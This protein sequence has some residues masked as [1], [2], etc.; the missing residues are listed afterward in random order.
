MTIGLVLPAVPGYS[1]TFFKNKILGLQ[2]YGH[3]VV[4]FVG[5]SKA[6]PE[7]Y[8]NC[9]V[10][11]APKLRGNKVLVVVRSIVELLKATLFQPKKSLRL[12]QL[13]RKDGISLLQNIK[14]I[15]LN[16]FLMNEPLDWLHFGFGTMA[17][18][19]ENLAKAI[20][21][22]MAVSFRGYDYYVYPE[23]NKDCYD[24]LFS[25]KV[26][27]H[28]L[29]DGMKKGLMTKGISESYITKIT[30]AIDLNLFKRPDTLTNSILKLTTIARLHSIK[31]LEYTLEALVL[32]KQ[33]GQS[34]QYV[35]IGDGPEKERLQIAAHQ[36][37]LTDNVTFAGVLSP[38][39]V[40]QQLN[41]ADIYIQYSIQEGFCNAV[42]E[43][44]AMGCLCVVSDAEGLS[45]NV[46][47]GQTGWV[48]PKRQPELL[49]QKLKQVLALDANHK[50][51][52][53]QRAIERVK[54]EF[55]LEKQGQEF[56]EF[57]K[58]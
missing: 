39:D 33:Q 51:A 9:K 48:V 29:S 35:I 15:I 45:E 10:V 20:E 30:P 16:Q 44:Q 41:S 27:Y 32:L 4:L 24:Y 7:N 18:G 1:E 52:V 55:N 2:S 21:A 47:D 12:F 26:Y 54:K 34:F 14:Q 25:K 50:E 58:Q 36:L 6:I 42:L 40:R 57:Y 11:K 56:L 46:L 3:D 31:G 8:L 22:K 5:Y 37:G 23:K 19:R 43:A 49:M 13:N 17:L 28:T 53:K 38:E